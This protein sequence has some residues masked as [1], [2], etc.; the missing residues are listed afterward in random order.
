MVLFHPIPIHQMSIGQVPY[1]PRTRHRAITKQLNSSR[2]LIMSNDNSE[3]DKPAHS[4]NLFSQEMDD[5]TPIA[6]SN[7]HTHKRQHQ[8][9]P[10]HAIRRDDAQ[11][12]TNKDTNF[13]S[14]DNIQTLDSHAV[15][16]YKCDG[17]QHGVFKKLRLGQY[18]IDARLDLHRKTV[19]E[20]RRE[21]YQ[22][23][24]DCSKYGVRSLMLVHGKGERNAEDIAMLKSCM[25]Q[26]LPEFDEVLAFH[27]AQ[28]R[29]GGTG[30][31]YV[32]LKKN[33]EEKS[34]NR[35]KFRPGNN[36]QPDD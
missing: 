35:E 31:V 23:I 33:D 17:V 1:Y 27:S 14:I 9:T 29:H 12:R 18:Q 25:N 22:F 11:Q 10:G 36:K 20:A 7:T 30:A 6:D 28:K 32:L 21:T 24:K 2:I 8:D 34:T 4:D 15:L 3:H 19:D 13:L 16:S 5:V 26:W